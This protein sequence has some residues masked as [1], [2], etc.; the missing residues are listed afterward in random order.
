MNTIDTLSQHTLVGLE[1]VGTAAFALSGVLGAMRKRMDVVGI[2]VC[3]F[4]AAFGGGTLRDVLIDRRP[5]FWSEHQE[6]LLGVL[7][8]CIACVGF[9]DLKSQEARSHRPYSY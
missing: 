9:F 7:F 8:L 4:L 2:C 6:V 5:F 3:G 1:L